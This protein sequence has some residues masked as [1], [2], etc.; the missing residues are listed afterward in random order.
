MVNGAFGKLVHLQF[1]DDNSIHRVWLEFQNSPKIG[2]C[3]RKKSAQ[4]VIQ[5]KLSNTTVPIELRT[6]NIQLTRDKKVTNKR[7]HFPIIAACAMTIHKSQGGTF[8]EIVYQYEKIHTRDMV[9]V[10]LSRVTRIE[11]LFITTPADDKTKFK[12]YQNRQ[13][14]S[15]SLIQEFQR[16]SLNTLETRASVIT[17]LISNN[18]I[19]LYTFNCQSLHSHKD[20]LSD[21]ISQKCDV[22]LLTEMWMKNEQKIHIPNFRYIA[23]FKRDE[24]RAA[25][26]AIYQNITDVTNIITPNMEILVN[27]SI[28]FSI[29]HNTVGD[30]CSATYKLEN[31][32][33]LLMVA[34]ISISRQVRKLRTSFT[35]FTAHFYSIQK[36][37][38]LYLDGIRTKFH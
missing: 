1:K 7:T 13:Q 37:D 2:Q 36:E 5:E 27:N 4:L 30:I 33:E 19:S 14:S 35:L 23:Q 8:D 38:Q 31:G 26:V 29:S 11:R 16:L 24:T 17:N 25:G 20:D 34:N 22:L 3:P 18:K 6:A 9:Y 21:S 12:F 15:S 28:G 10:G 32:A